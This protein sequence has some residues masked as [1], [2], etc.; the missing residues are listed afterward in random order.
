MSKILRV[1]TTQVLVCSVLTFCAPAL[2]AQES[3]PMV[4][5]YR[6]WPTLG[7]GYVVNAPNAYIGFSAMRIMP[8]LFGGAGLYADVKFTHDTPEDDIA[9]TTL[10]TVPEARAN[11]DHNFEHD[12]VWFSANLALVYAIT[13]EVAAYLGGGYSKQKH[14]REFFDTTLTRGFEGFYWIYD[15][16]SSGNRVN[17]LGGLMMR[18][19]RNLTIQIGGETQPLGATV[20]LMITL[21]H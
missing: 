3:R 9:F 5:D 19:A 13:H 12:D 6:S 15:E 17:A 2:S 8:K 18:A 11:G 1:L 4:P 14:Y 16:A 21:P 10:Y 20:G 7:V